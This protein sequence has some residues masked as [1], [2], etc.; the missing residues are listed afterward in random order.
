MSPETATTRPWRQLFSEKYYRSNLALLA[1]DEAHCVYE[2]LVGC[3]YHKRC[4]VVCY[5]HFSYRGSDF[6]KSFAGIGDLR[7]LTKAP[8]IALTAS[9]PPHVEA[10]LVKSL[11]LQNTVYIK[12]PLDRPNTFYAVYK[13]TSMVVRVVKVD[14]FIV[15]IVILL[16]LDFAGIASGLSTQ[17]DPS[18]IPKTIIFFGTKEL[19]VKAY[20]YLRRVT[21]FP[22]YVGAYHA[23]LT[24]HSKHFVL[25]QFMSSSSEMRCLCCTIAFGMVMLTCL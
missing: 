6:R 22:H 4:T 11:H 5:S 1:V 8:V 18:T 15:Y 3:W 23:D 10:E 14:D 25:Q 24:Q 7:A 19:A 21:S 2:W 17:D 13:K 9:A 12:Q 16:Q 20:C